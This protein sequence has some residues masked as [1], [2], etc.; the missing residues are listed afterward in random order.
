MK[1]RRGF[2]FIEILVVISIIGMLAALLGF[3]VGPVMKERSTKAVCVSNMHQVIS[4]V[5]LYMSDYDGELP[6]DALDFVPMEKY[7]GVKPS[8]LFCPKSRKLNGIVVD[9]YQDEVADYHAYNAEKT[10]A[11]KH[12]FGVIAPDFDPDTDAILKCTEHT[13]GRFVK[14]NVL[15]FYGGL[16]LS[17]KVQ[18]A[19]L[20][21]H[22]S[23]GHFNPCWRLPFEAASDDLVTHPELVRACEGT[24]EK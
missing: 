4:A 1:R 16:N 6:Q 12:V 3:V 14:N 24:L 7:L 20:D 19:Y 15:V 23:Y 21:G 9:A 10:K 8:R 17:A 5:H 18:S 2:T 11:N 13:Q 22:V